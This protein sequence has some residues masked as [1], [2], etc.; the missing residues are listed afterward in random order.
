MSE[1][2]TLMALIFLTLSLVEG[3]SGAQEP[4]AAFVLFQEG[5]DLGARGDYAGACSKFAASLALRPKLGTRLNLGDCSEH[6]GRTATARAH[7]LE[8]AAMARQEGDA[9][10]AEYAAGR[11]D[12]LAGRI[13]HLVLRGVPSSRDARL[14]IDGVVTPAGEGQID[15]SLD[16]GD[17]EL[18]LEVPGHD[19]WSRKVHLDEKAQPLV[20]DVPPLAA[21]LAESTRQPPPIASDTRAPAPRTPSQRV[22]ALTAAG[23]GVVGLG[24][25]TLFG[26]EASSQWSDAKRNCPHLPACTPKGVQETSDANQSALVSTVSFGIGFAAVAAGAALWWTAPATDKAPASPPPA[27]APYVGTHEAGVLLQGV[28]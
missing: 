17:H 22:A 5:R 8:A 28:F 27:A 13:P 14:R 7:F 23:A 16:P 19:T 12:A 24:I 20:L 1:R 9:S 21:P 4:D 11:A 3:A 26:L 18:F 2:W 15:V 10:R 6:L 25:G